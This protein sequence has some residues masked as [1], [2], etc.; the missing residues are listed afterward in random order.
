[1]DIIVVPERGFCFGVRRAMTMAEKALAQH[2][3]LSC[4]RPVFVA[5]HADHVTVRAENKNRVSFVESNAPVRPACDLV[6][7][8]WP[9]DLVP[10]WPS[11]IMPADFAPPDF[12]DKLFAKRLDFGV[13][14]RTFF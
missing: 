4:F 11:R 9:V 12:F 3:E 8:E 10:C 14:G 2:G 5:V 13:S 1:M 6:D 7:V